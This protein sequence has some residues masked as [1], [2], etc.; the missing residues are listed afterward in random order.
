MC[1][2]LRIKI[3]QCYVLTVYISYVHITDSFI[4]VKVKVWLNFI[5]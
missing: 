4:I 1:H 2:S 5:D 3:Y